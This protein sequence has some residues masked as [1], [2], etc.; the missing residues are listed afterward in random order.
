MEAVAKFREIIRKVNAQTLAKFGS[1]NDDVCVI[2]SYSSSS[3]SHFRDVTLI[4]EYPTSTHVKTILYK[5]KRNM[6]KY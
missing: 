4:M 2:C 5:R 6:I 3:A 1:H